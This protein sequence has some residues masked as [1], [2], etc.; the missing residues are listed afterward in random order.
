[1]LVV[2]KI[3]I[4]LT[5]CM[6]QPKRAQIRRC[7]KL[8]SHSTAERRRELLQP[9]GRSARSGLVPC[10]QCRLGVGINHS[11]SSNFVT[12]SHHQSIS[13]STRFHIPHSTP[14]D[15]M[16]S[17]LARIRISRRTRLS[18][19]SWQHLGMMIDTRHFACHYDPPS[20]KFGELWLR[21]LELYAA[22]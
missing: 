12:A 13:G 9:V 8:S 7:L 5:A 6:N 1:M 16:F 18:V 19:L 10:R 17:L 3:L 15:Q 4:L 2:G 14:V 11:N 21:I 22:L 20:A